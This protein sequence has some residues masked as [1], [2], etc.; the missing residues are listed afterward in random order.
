MPA[1]GWYWPVISSVPGRD[2]GPGPRL[3]LTGVEGR[4]SITADG[5]PEKV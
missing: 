2:A 1:S 4:A 5:G 3:H